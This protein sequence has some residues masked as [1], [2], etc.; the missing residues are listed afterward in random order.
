MADRRSVLIRE[1]SVVSIVVILLHCGSAARL[2]TAEARLRFGFAKDG[3]A[4]FEMRSAE[5][6][7]RKFAARATGTL[8]IDPVANG[9]AASSRR[10]PKAVATSERNC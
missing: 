5:K 4:D 1:N 3:L 10:S 2:W 8:M 7:R 9:K 6:K